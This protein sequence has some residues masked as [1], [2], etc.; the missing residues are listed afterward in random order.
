MGL[1]HAQVI[2]NYLIYRHGLSAGSHVCNCINGGLIMNMLF[3]DLKVLSVFYM[4]WTKWVKQSSRTAH[5]YGTPSRWFYF[6][7]NENV[8]KETK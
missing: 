1:N 6:G 8:K 7:K 3:S 2:R 5:I 4:N